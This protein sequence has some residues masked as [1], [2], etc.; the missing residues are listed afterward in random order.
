[1]GFGWL[2]FPINFHL[3][4]LL[5]LF[6]WWKTISRDALLLLVVY[7][8]PIISIAI[9]FCVCPESKYKN[10]GVDRDGI[11]VDDESQIVR[12][13]HHGLFGN[14]ARKSRRELSV[15]FA[16][17]PPLALTAGLPYSSLICLS[18]YRKL[19]VVVCAHNGRQLITSN[20]FIHTLLLVHIRAGGLLHFFPWFH[21]AY[22]LS[23]LSLSLRCF[24]LFIDG[25]KGR[26]FP[27]LF[28]VSPLYG[29]VVVLLADKRNTRD[30]RKNQNFQ[31]VL[32]V[33]HRS[34]PLGETG[35]T[36]CHTWNNTAER[37]HWQQ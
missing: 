13:C 31:L 32:N 1:M 26:D 4:L 15:W 22:L 34:D 21:A 9:T 36:Q 27:P 11:V 23:S 8:L 17:T 2:P 25:R 29:P 12:G 19:V 20:T 24:W 33:L 28:F 35:E 14:L 18:T 10:N 5:S 30:G 16:A 7:S 37:W 6:F 3:L